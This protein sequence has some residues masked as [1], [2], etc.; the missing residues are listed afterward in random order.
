MAA[1][2]RPA[3]SGELGLLSLFDLGQV[4]MLN[5][6]TG[7]LAVL[8]ER[9]KGYLYFREGQLVNAVDEQLSEGEGAAYRLFSWSR[10]TFE[11][12]QE[13]PGGDP[14][15]HE[16]TEATMLEAARR[17][18]ESGDSSGATGKLLERQD[19]MEAL[20]DVFQ[21]LAREARGLSPDSPR[22]QASGAL[23]ALARPGDRMLLRP[24]HPVR[25]RT[26]GAWREARD[27]ALSVAEYEDMRTRLGVTADAGGTVLAQLPGG[28]TLSVTRVTDA[29]SEALWLQPVALPAPDPARLA[30]A[31]EALAGLLGTSR[32]LVLIGAVDADAASRLLHAVVASRLQKPSESVLLISEAGVYRHRE[33]AGA[34][35]EARA[36][37][38]HE[39]LAALEPATVALDGVPLPGT[40]QLQAVGGVRLLIARTLGDA[41]ETLLPR[42]LAG[43]GAADRVALEA[44]VASAPLLLV[45]AEPAEGDANGL[46]FQ[47]WPSGAVHAERPAPRAARAA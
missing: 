33:S 24:G 15:I 44:F 45:I 4:L 30:A 11:F 10:G 16:S 6:A 1:T 39:T 37:A 46:A 27:A 36:G 47:A 20:R 40:G 21:N 25:L 3:F 43:F 28:R 34:L 13:P 18:D 2:P 32:G 7:V 12:R 8:S 38:I 41:P 31:P 9:R 14:I 17:M 5:R 19:A 35:I 42:W 23:D 22:A 26:G 29:R